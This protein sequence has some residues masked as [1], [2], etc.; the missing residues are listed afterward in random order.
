LGGTPRPIDDIIIAWT[1]DGSRYAARGDSP[2]EIKIVDRLTGK[3]SSITL[4]GQIE[5]VLDIDWSPVDERLL[6]QSIDQKQFAVWTTKTDGTQQ[7]K[8]VEDD[9]PILSPR[10]SSKGNAIY[11][12]RG[13]GLEQ[14]ATELWKIPLSRKTGKA[15]HSSSLVFSGLQM[16][17]SISLTS[18]GKYLLYTRVFQFSNLWQAMIEG[19]GKSQIVR[20]KQL[21]SGTLLDIHPSL[22]PDGKF[23]AF[24]RGSGET[25]NIYVISTEGGNPTQ[26]TFLNSTNV[27]PVWSP[28]GGEIAFWSNEGGEYRVWKVSARGGRPYLFAKT[29]LGRS[30]QITWAPGPNIIYPRGTKED[31][32]GKTNFTVLNPKTEEETPLV[33]GESEIILMNN[34]RY[35]PEGK[36]VAVCTHRG[37]WIIS[38]EDSSKKLVG[39]QDQRLF[40]FGWSTDGKWLYAYEEDI[41]TGKR[42]YFI[43]D[44]ENGKVKPLPTFAFTIEGR[45]YYKV[46]DD[47]PEIFVDEKTHSDVWVIDNFDQIIR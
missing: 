40:P 6:I 36:R 43:G 27:R 33:K 13:S 18:D 45:T 29:E 35:S 44:I 8:L 47:K 1:P 5:T 14:T 46:V 10:W 3:S 16:G 38:L 39:Q 11:Y 15:A 30:T 26:L 28:D 24:S 31:A 25:S 4:N 23:A 21:T 9:M 41:E 22:S 19:S 34:P 2:K 32:T 7:Y 37:L 42:R 12:L 20:T 17:D